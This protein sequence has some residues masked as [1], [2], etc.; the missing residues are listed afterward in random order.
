[1]TEKFRSRLMRER[2]AY[3]KG[4]RRLESV[5][6]SRYT[7][8]VDIDFLHI[9]PDRRYRIAQSGWGSLYHVL[10]G[11]CRVEVKNGPAQT[12]VAGGCAA[13][14]SGRAHVIGAVDASGSAQDEAALEKRPTRD[15]DYGKDKRDTLVL[16]IRV[17]NNSHLLPEIL[18]PAIFLDPDQVRELRGLQPLID[19]LQ[20][21]GDLSD[22]IHHLA[23]C[24]IS[25]ALA[26]L[27]LTQVMQRMDA[28]IG[29]LLEDG[30]DGRIKAAITAIHRD[31]SRHWT[32]ATL[33]EEVNLSRSSF[34]ERFRK[35]VGETP[36]HYVSRIRINLASSYLQSLDWAIADIA[37]EVGYSS[38]GAFINAFKRQMGVS[39]GKFRRKAR[40]HEQEP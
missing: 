12:V 9:P 35:V 15:A 21:F 39:P 2:D 29:E 25:D 16:R 13:V 36:M 3:R 1:M 8:E 28:P 24:R 11:A 10:A 37:Q 17:S 31:P 4:S 23:K 30:F 34:A 22:P 14:P 18:P 6:S 38:E 33:A 40:L 5:F 20:A 19:A 27:L 32:L 7:A 26:M